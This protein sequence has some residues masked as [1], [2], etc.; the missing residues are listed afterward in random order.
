MPQYIDYAE[1]YDFDIAT[2]PFADISFYLEYAHQ[3]GSPILELAC[4]TGRVLIPLAKAG[5]E[6][7]GLLIDIFRDY[8]RNP[9]DGTG[10]IIAVA[11]RPR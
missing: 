11:R 10:E 9:Y 7:H 3:C 6:M 4:G 1:Y 8:D 5:F 2:V